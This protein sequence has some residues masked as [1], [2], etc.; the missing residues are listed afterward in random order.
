M[1]NLEYYL[2]VSGITGEVMEVHRGSMRMSHMSLGFGRRQN[3]DGTP[4]GGVLPKVVT[5]VREY[6]GSSVALGTR[7]SSRLT[8]P[9][10]KFYTTDPGL[11]DVMVTQLTDALIESVTYLGRRGGSLMPEEKLTLSY[12]TLTV[13]FFKQDP[14]SLV[15]V[16]AGSYTY[17]PKL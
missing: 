2:E 10:I 11:G 8:I 7:A 3:A 14:V 1:P 13:N 4:T 12:R 16:P 17:Q 5:L 6:D 9:T 15:L